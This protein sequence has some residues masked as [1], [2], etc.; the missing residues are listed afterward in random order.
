M[1]FPLF[2]FC[3]II[4]GNVSFAMVEALN[5][6]DNFSAENETIAQIRERVDAFGQKLYVY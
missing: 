2:S 3:I 6:H 1:I 5:R 4:S